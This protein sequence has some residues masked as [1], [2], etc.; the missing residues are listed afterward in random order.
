[1][2]VPE[3]ARALTLAGLADTSTRTPMV[4]AVPTTGDAE[5]L[6]HDLSAFL[7]SDQID[8]FPAWETL[9]FE[10]VSPSV[11]TM[12][13][14][15]RT[16]WR[17]RNP[18]RIPEAGDDESGRGAPRVIVAP[19]RALVQRL[20]APRGGLEPVRGGAGGPGDPR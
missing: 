18:E 14:R 7:G 15:L 12:G 19:A 16:M 17:L 10:R 1:M 8:L 2:A 5:R 3:P 20:R 11:E 9:P 4:V 13:R 6:A